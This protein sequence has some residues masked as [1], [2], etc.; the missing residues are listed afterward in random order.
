[1]QLLTIIVSSIIGI[2]LQSCCNHSISD[3]CSIDLGNYEFV[4]VK[5]I[6]D[7]KFDIENYDIMKYMRSSKNIK[8]P[9]IGNI[10]KEVKMFSSEK[11]DTLTAIVYGKDHKYF[12]I[13][14]CYFES[15]IPILP[16]KW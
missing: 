12:K 9:I 8:G 5:Y 13:G 10:V 3:K 14:K 7:V 2:S 15:D 1:M 6:N 4:S 11:G 16:D